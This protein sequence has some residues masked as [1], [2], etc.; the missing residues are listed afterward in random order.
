MAGESP[1]DSQY[2]QEIFYPSNC[3]YRLWARANLLCSRYGGFL[4]KWSGWDMKL[5]IQLHLVPMVRLGGSVPPLHHITS[6]PGRPFKAIFF[7]T[8]S[9]HDKVGEPLWS[10]VSKLRIIFLRKYFARGNLSLPA[11][12]FRLFQWR[13]SSPSGP[14]HDVHRES[15]TFTMYTP[16][17]KKCWWP[18]TLHDMMI[19]KINVIIWLDFASTAVRSVS[20]PVLLRNRVLL[21]L[22]AVKSCQKEGSLKIPC[23]ALLLR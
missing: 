2:G 3:P 8:L 12:Y 14:V 13:L 19:T 17:K 1:F 9:A 23:K 5:T 15:F 4:R 7:K 21:Y 20:F 18:H 16:S 6:W 22:S 10:G 11:P